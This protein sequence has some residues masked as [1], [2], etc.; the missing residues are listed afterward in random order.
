MGFKL[1][2][3]PLFCPF[4]WPTHGHAHLVQVL[5]LSFKTSPLY[6]LP[7]SATW[8]R[9]RLLEATVDLDTHRLHRKQTHFTRAVWI[10]PND[11][12]VELF[13]LHAR[14]KLVKLW[15]KTC[16]VSAGP[17]VEHAVMSP[18]HESVSGTRHQRKEPEVREATKTTVLWFYTNN[19]CHSFVPFKQASKCPSRME[20]GF[21]DG[22]PCL[23]V[24]WAPFTSS[25]TVRFTFM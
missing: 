18:K 2:N 20:F 12:L 16:S 6:L 17:R 21:C 5:L 19:H 22:L 1:V 15:Q 3:K 10:S 11:V 7:S 25:F 13:D 9:G 4:L 23:D 24:V 14:L 8:R